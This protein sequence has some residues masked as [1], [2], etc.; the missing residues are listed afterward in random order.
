MIYA[1]ATSSAFLRQSIFQQ[2]A[3]RLKALKVELDRHKQMKPELVAMAQAKSSATQAGQAAEQQA[4]APLAPS[5]A[6]AASG[7]ASGATGM[8]GTVPL[9]P[10]R[11]AQ[12]PA[13]PARTA[14]AASLQL[15]K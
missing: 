1:S 7:A 5:A 8:T 10:Q 14:P 12:Q 9:T 2:S 15:P 4:A 6:S 11:V 13:P 3:T